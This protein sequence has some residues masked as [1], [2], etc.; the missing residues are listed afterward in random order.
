ML[1]T[2]EQ[3]VNFALTST[4][5]FFVYLTLKKFLPVRSNRKWMEIIPFLVLTNFASPAIYPEE[6]FVTVSILIAFA[7]Y[8]FVFFKGTVLEKLSVCIVLYPMMVSLN[9]LTED[10]GYQIWHMNMEMSYLA[11]TLLH[12]FTIFLRLPVWFLIWKASGKWTCKARELTPRMW[13]VI[14][15]LCLSSAVGLI[16]FIYH[17]PIGKGLTTYPASL[18]CFLTSIGCIYLTSYA[19]KTIRNEMEIQNLKYQQAYYEQMEQNQASVRKIRHDMNNHLSVISSFLQDGKNSEALKYLS[20]LSGELVT[21]NRIFC[22]NPIVNA[23]LNSKY[24]KAMSSETDCFFNISIDG[25]MGMD[26]ISLCSLF[27]N[28]LDNAIEACEK[29][30]APEKRRISVK[31]RYQ[32]GTLCYE[33]SN[34]KINEIVV[35][36]GRFLTG[37]KEKSVHGI[38]VQNIRDIV[39]KYSGDLNIDFTDNDFTVTVFIPSC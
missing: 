32:K 24:N 9:Y 16:T 26:D 14:D 5:I 33:I 30:P 4:Y 25:I 39:E 31:A 22:K 18:A 35:K 37:K 10:L 38:G 19:A 6:L 12:T 8:L 3:I 11:Q 29:I 13:I 28:T 7:L 23:V 34:S 20:G 2:I 17:T 15:I 21:G 1:T 36:G 27:A